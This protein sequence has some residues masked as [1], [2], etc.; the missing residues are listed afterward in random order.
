MSDLQS[1]LPTRRYANTLLQDLHVLPCFA[2]SPMFNDEDNSLLRD[3][4]AL[5]SHYTYFTVDDQTGVQLSAAEA[6]ERHCAR[7]GMLQRTAMKNFK[8]KLTV[9]ALSNYGSIDQRAEL[10]GLLEPLTGAEVVALCGFLDLRT[11]YPEPTGV[12]VGR[13]FLTEVLLSTFER[14]K[15]FQ[16]SARELSILPTEQSLFEQ[17]L[18]RPDSYDG[19]HPLALPKLNLQYLSVGDFLWR[20]L[21]LYRCESFYAVRQDIETALRRLKPELRQAGE[22]IF[23][24]SSRMALSIPRPSYVFE[25]HLQ[26]GSF[27]ADFRSVLTVVP[28]VVGD[29]KPATVKAEIVIDLRHVGE[30]VRREW[31]SLRIDDTVFLLAVD[32]SQ[33]KNSTNGAAAALTDAQKLGLSV[34]R[35]AEVVQI[36][37]DRGRLMRESEAG[38]GRNGRSPLRRLQ[39]RLDAKVYKQDMDR[40]SDGKPNVY[41]GINL[42]VRRSGRENNFKAVL[43]SIQSLT[44]SEVPL[45]SWLHEVF[46]GYGDPAGATYK[47]LPNRVK[48]ID[49]RDT[50]LDWQHLIESL[51]GKTVEPSDD[52][53]GSFG[54]PYVLESVDRPPA[55]AD[56]KP[57][58]K[59]RRRDAEPVLRSEV[60]TLKVSTYKPPNNGPYPVDTPKM[61]S[62]RFTP[63]QAEAIISGSQPG[64]TVIVGPPGRARPMLQRR[65]SATSTIISPSSAPS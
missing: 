11:G 48:K 14:R 22:T 64:L 25:A 10:E 9:L 65:S 47:N 16:D 51:P 31:D 53:S 8:E 39:L 57:P 50:F 1:Q 17:G 54:P 43:E 45:A 55:E 24:G 33:Q 63:A 38:F 28:P 62:V 41:G 26:S 13:K 19:T 5:L 15:T 12:P 27:P 60:E 2:L 30:G 35:S 42:I 36:I 4:H 58:S 21:V 46:L 18:L 6:Y 49:F 23:T 3:L 37:D 44:L 29:D 7:L 56:A 52:A 32:A 20:S 61:N 59:K 34:V 40:A